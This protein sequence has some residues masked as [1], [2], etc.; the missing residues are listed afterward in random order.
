MATVTLNVVNINDINFLTVPT[1]IG[2]EDLNIKYVFTHKK[3]TQYDTANSDVL[4]YD[5]Q[6][7]KLAVIAVEETPY[8]IFGMYGG[9]KL[10][11]AERLGATEAS[12]AML[13]N[14]S[15]TGYQV[16]LSAKDPLSLVLITYSALAGGV[17]NIGDTITGDTTYA[18]AEVVFDNGAD[19]MV[20]HPVKGTL[21]T[22]D[23]I[24]N[25]ATPQVSA[26]IDT[27]TAA[28][29]KYLQYEEGLSVAAKKK[30]I[31]ARFNV[32]SADRA[33]TAVDLVNNTV[34][35]AGDHEADFTKDVPLFWDGSTANDGMYSV[36]SSLY[37][38]A[39]VITLNQP[40]PNYIADGTLKFA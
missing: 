35:I 31:V 19:F 9:F 20:I 7:S 8:D 37:G 4:Y 18:T 5:E 24:S 40:I 28:D 21:S 17:F 32:L 29:Q 14:T 3:A 38:S 23:A 12:K 33:V 26:D 30:D 13:I 1:A 16:A 6:A 2:I 36:K 39:T 22:A 25:T 27:Y 11:T 34:T 10:I 15:S